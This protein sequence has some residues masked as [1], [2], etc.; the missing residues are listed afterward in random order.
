M[1]FPINKAPLFAFKNRVDIEQQ[2]MVGCYSC[3]HIFEVKDIKDYTDDGKTVL[4]PRCATDAVLPC[5][6]ND[7]LKKIHDYF[8]INLK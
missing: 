4:C 8:V 1:N 3:L 6:D 7:D 5:S 2:N